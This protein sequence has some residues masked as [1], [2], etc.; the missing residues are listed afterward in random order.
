MESG[1]LGQREQLRREAHAWMAQ[2]APL[3]S[4]DPALT[5]REIR[6]RL[7]RLQTLERTAPDLFL[8]KSSVDPEDQR[9]LDTLGA[10]L[11]Q[12]PAL[13]EGLRRRLAQVAPGDPEGQVDLERLRERLAEIEAKRELGMEVGPQSPGSLQLKTS[14]G[15]IGGAVFL[16]LFGI[17]WTAFTTVHAVLLI[18]GMWRAL[19]P[20]ALAL[21]P[22][23]AI[24]WAVGIGMLA[25]AFHAAADESIELVGN[26]LRVRRSVAGFRSE[27]TYVLDP[28]KP[29]REERAAGSAGA[30]RSQS[31]LSKAIVLTDQDGRPIAIGMGTTSSHRA[32]MVRR[33][34]AFL[35]A[36]RD[37]SSGIS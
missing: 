32:E 3:L 20:L 14:P 19:G 6:E 17:G 29:A 30:F 33:I 2:F 24:F 18:G 16:G 28:T 15:N 8:L 31:R 9:L 22:F 27:R 13:E 12:I 37:P 7:Q 25:G 10:A 1:A 5:D 21:L 35:A 11:R 34:N 36:V 4:E 23:Y 26:V